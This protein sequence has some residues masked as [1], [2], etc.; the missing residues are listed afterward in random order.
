VSHTVGVSS[1]PLSKAVFW[2]SKEGP[3]HV[4]CG[5][6]DFWIWK[7]WDEPAVH[8]GTR[9]W[10]GFRVRS[11][12]GETVHQVDGKSDGQRLI[13]LHLLD[14][15]IVQAEKEMLS[16]L[17]SLS[18]EPIE[19]KVSRDINLLGTHGVADVALVEAVIHPAVTTPLEALAFQDMFIVTKS[20]K[21]VD[22]AAHAWP[23]DLR[24]ARDFRSRLLAPV[25]YGDHLGIVAGCLED[26]VIVRSSES[27][28]VVSMHDLDPVMVDTKLRKL[29]GGA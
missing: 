17:A 24:S 2:S 16:K 21:I 1:D 28:L 25:K 22:V 27:R 10:T 4:K 20:A 7:L 29:I 15:K 5:H 8:A 14:P 13:E 12:L 26:H 3:L 19:T 6:E 11:A 23:I 18:F 9:Q